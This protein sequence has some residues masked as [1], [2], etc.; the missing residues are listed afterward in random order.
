MPA[1]TTLLRCDPTTSNSGT[2]A[3]SP[4]QDCSNPASEVQCHSFQ[5]LGG[6]GRLSNCRQPYP[7]P[8]PELQM[9]AVTLGSPFCLCWTF[10]SGLSNVGVALGGLWNV[11]AWAASL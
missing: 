7:T 8:Q 6:A 1:M 2:F 3:S 11:P 9:G 5:N 4:K 10:F